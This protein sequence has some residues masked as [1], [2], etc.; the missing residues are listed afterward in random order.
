MCAERAL[1]RQLAEPTQ[2][3]NTM[4]LMAFKSTLQ[5]A[6][7]TFHS[8]YCTL[9]SNAKAALSEFPNIDDMELHVLV[10]IVNR[11][12]D[13]L[14]KP[15]W[16]HLLCDVLGGADTELSKAYGGE[17][18]AIFPRNQVDTMTGEVI[19]TVFDELAVLTFVN[20]RSQCTYSCLK[21]V[22]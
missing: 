9:V 5:S 20:F 18:L 8:A 10:G 13:H 15:A 4:E 7:I 3:V 17:A 14:I 6:N 12:L 21:E 19:R 22:T 2:V 11:E 1:H 16:V